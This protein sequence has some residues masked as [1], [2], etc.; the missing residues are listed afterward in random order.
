VKPGAARPR[1]PLDGVRVVSF[2]TFIAGAL[3]PML[4]ADLGADVIKVEPPGGDPFRAGTSF[5]FLG[6]NRGTRSL[7]VD[8]Q[9]DEGRELVLRLV[10]RAD[11]VVDNFRAGVLARL[12]FDFASLERRNPRVVQVSITGY[13]PD[14]PYAELPCFDPIMQARS[15]LARAQSGFDP[16]MYTVAYTDYATAT[17]AAL[18]A[19][20][21]LH[22]RDRAPDAERHGQAAWTSLL[23]NACAMQAGFLIEYAGRPPDP[24]GAPDLRGTSAWRRAYAAADGWLFVAAQDEVQ[25]RA[26]ASALGV[27]ASTDGEDAPVAGALAQRIAGALGALPLERALATLRAAGVPAVAC[28]TFP[29]IVGD[30]QTSA[31]GLWW[32]ATHP[33]LGEVVQTGAVL[34]FS[35]TPM[36]LGPVAPLLGE[37][38][39]AI[40][41]EAGVDEATIERLVATGVVRQAAVATATAQPR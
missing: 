32:R 38:S 11:L 6:W 12:G 5:G 40:L 31:N 16:T 35:R 25:R 27:A 14:G 18:A 4:L 17:M 9:Q 24:P 30:E 36:R 34:G 21:A 28:P 8:L 2:A 7:A 15:G 29:E 39:L 1:A 37:H 22:A 26:L 41:R 19:V 10:D 13:G 3:C 33:E 23:A 20:A